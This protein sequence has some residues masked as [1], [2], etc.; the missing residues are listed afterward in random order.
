MIEII[1][2]N[3]NQFWVWLLVFSNE[4][5]KLEVEIMVV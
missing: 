4:L 1:N 2:I 3:I 5:I